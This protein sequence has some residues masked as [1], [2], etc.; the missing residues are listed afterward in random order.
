MAQANVVILKTIRGDVNQSDWDV[1][2][3]H[4]ETVVMNVENEGIAA[5]FVRN[6]NRGIPLD[7]QGVLSVIRITDKRT[8]LVAQ[9]YMDLG[10]YILRTADEKDEA[11]LYFQRAIRATA[12]DVVWQEEIFKQLAS[13]GRQDW[14]AKL[15]QSD[16]LINHGFH[17]SDIHHSSRQK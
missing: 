16:W 2:L 17:E 15:R 7:Q 1:L 8:S 6:S 11:F 9:D 10:L 3:E 12:G 5:N 4:L 14:V 13:T